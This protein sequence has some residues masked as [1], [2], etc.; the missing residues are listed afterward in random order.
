MVDEEWESKNPEFVMNSTTP[1]THFAVA[2]KKEPTQISEFRVQNANA[3][4]TF[5]PVVYD[6][7]LWGSETICD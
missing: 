6:T 4:S 3:T 2:Q 5:F 7:T 1:V